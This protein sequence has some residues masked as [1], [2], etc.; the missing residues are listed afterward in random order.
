MSTRAALSGFSKVSIP[1]NVNILIGIYYTNI[2]NKSVIEQPEMLCR[3]QI[4]DI[5]VIAAAK[6]S[7]LLA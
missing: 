4:R 5:R 3:E 1:C 7:P 6:P 2:L